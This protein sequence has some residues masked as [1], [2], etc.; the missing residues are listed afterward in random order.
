METKDKKD[1]LQTWTLTN[2]GTRYVENDFKE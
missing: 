2:S 1:N